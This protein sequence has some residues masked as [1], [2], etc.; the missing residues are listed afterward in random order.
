MGKAVQKARASREEVEE[1]G[2]VEPTGRS[3]S[4]SSLECKPCTFDQIAKCGRMS[5]CI[6]PLFLLSTYYSFILGGII[7]YSMMVLLMLVYYP[8]TVSTV[9]KFRSG[10][11]PSLHD[12]IFSRYRDVA[13]ESECCCHSLL[14]HF[15]FP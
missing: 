13:D 15:S 4:F 2:G 6:N 8:S 11:R 7:I 3:I 12:P 10:A 5:H 9:L 14:S 1:S